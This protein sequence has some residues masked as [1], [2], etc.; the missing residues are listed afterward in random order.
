[1]L[2]PRNTQ[3]EGDLHSFKEFTSSYKDRDTEYDPNTV[4]QTPDSSSDLVDMKDSE[5]S[6]MSGL[7]LNMVGDI[8]R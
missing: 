4:S 7:N 8:P 1:M 2:Q 3:I 6:I 5:M